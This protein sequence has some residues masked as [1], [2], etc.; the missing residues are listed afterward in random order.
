MKE[1]NRYVY[2]NYYD[3]DSDDDLIFI[4]ENRVINSSFNRVKY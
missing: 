2:M 3:S 1:I 4:G